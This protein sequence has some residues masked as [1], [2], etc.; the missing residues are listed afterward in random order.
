MPSKKEI[1]LDQLS[2]TEL[3]NLIDEWIHNAL[4]R[5]ILRIRLLDG[6]CY[7]QIAEK[8]NLSIEQTKK[9]A[10]TAIN[11]LKSHV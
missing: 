1:E 2:T 11:K 5:K 6:E 4:D 9:R 10:Y 3:N 7:S 8:F